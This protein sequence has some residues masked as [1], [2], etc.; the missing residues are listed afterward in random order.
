MTRWTVDTRRLLVQWER[1]SPIFTRIGG[2]GSFSVGGGCIGT[3][4]QV[5]EDD[6]EG[7]RISR[8]G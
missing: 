2:E 1:R 4:V 3:G 6:F 5:G 7:G 8:P